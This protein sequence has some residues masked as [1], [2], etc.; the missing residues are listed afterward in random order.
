MAGPLADSFGRK[1]GMLIANIVVIIGSAVQAA[2]F[3]RRDIIAGRVILG[4]GSVLLGTF[5]VG[6]LAL[7]AKHGVQDPRHSLT[8]WRYP[9]PHIVEL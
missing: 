5:L 9:I 2:A 4:I 7:A 8:L 3:K 6:N 1:R